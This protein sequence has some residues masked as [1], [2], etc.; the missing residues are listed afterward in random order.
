MTP[1][2]FLVINKP[3]GLTSHD[4]VNRIR[5]VFKIKRVGH[6]GTLDPSVTGVLPIALGNATRLLPYLPGEKSYEGIIQ[7]GKSTTTDDHEGE[8]IKESFWP[9]IQKESLNKIL[10]KFRG[11]IK[12]RPPKVSSAHFKGERAYKLA[13]K[14]REFELEEKKID[15]Y[16]LSLINWNQEEGTIEIKVQCGA[17]TYI[18]SLARDLGAEIGCGGYLKRLNRTQALGFNIEEAIELS[19]LSD[20]NITN[21][22]LLLDP[23]NSLNHFKKL[24]MNTI[25]D[26]TRWRKGQQIDSEKL[27]VVKDILSTNDLY[28]EKIIRSSHVLIIDSEGSIAGVGI[29]KENGLIQPKVVFNAYG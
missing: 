27:Q 8:V 13:R 3:K 16:S 6:G 23:I 7:L 20:S 25:D 4:C 17:G 5:K 9:L 11:S 28:K 24:K 1:F 10:D 22:S 29:E 15:I 19:N 26:Q 18:R 2:G 12:Q 14:G 21:K